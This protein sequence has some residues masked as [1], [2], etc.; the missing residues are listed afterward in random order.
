M[1]EARAASSRFWRDRPNSK[2]LRPNSGAQMRVVARAI[3]VVAGIGAAAPAFASDLPTKKPAPAPI[4]VQALSDWHLGL[5]GYGWATSLAGNAGVGPFPTA[6]FFASFGDIL[7]HFEGASMGAAVA[8]NERFSGGLDLIWSRLGAAATFKDPSSPLF[9]VGA[10]IKLTETIVTAFGG[11]RIPVGPPNLQLYG[12][13]GARY[14]NIGASLTLKGPVFG[15]QTS[16]SA[17]RD[18]VDP[19]AGFVA[20]YRIDDKWFVSAEG[21]GGRHDRG[22]SMRD[23]RATRPDAS[24]AIDAGRASGGVGLRHL[25]RDEAQ[26]Q[27]AGNNLFH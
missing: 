17:S 1:R 5:I 4:L 16:A 23:N 12:T 13:L 20:R 3:F 27:Q 11:V 10:N 19:V 25:N 6:P 24:R 21:D 14:F 2:T 9:G 18:W 8:P 7:S 15:F 26:N 22:G